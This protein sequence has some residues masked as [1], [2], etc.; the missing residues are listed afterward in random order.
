MILWVKEKEKMAYKDNH[1]LHLYDVRIFIL[2]W[3]TATVMVTST[4]F[5]ISIP[6]TVANII[7]AGVVAGI[8]FKIIKIDYKWKQIF[9]TILI[10]L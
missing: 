8:L 7:L 1:S 3:M 5:I 4:L 6:I 10:S 2:L 9:S